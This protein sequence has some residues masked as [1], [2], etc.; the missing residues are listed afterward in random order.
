MH[1]NLLGMCNNSNNSADCQL[2]MFQPTRDYTHTHVWFE[3]PTR[4]A[5]LLLFL[6]ISFRLSH[7]VVLLSSPGCLWVWLV[8][9]R[10]FFC[11]WSFLLVHFLVW[12]DLSF[13]VLHQ[14]CCK[15]GR[16]CRQIGNYFDVLSLLQPAPRHIHLQWTD[17]ANL[18]WYFFSVS[19]SLFLFPFYLR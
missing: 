8:L 5:S 19:R 18:C 14:I 12:S 1:T 10:C 15:F 4:V 3:I 17:T 2:K 7:F 9:C 16:H 11:S 13:T 6:K